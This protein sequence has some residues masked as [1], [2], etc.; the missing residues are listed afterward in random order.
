GGAL[1]FELQ[2]TEPGIGTDKV[3][4]QKA[5]FF[6]KDASFWEIRFTYSD[7]VGINVPAGDLELV[8]GGAL[9]FNTY[10]LA[11]QGDGNLVLRDPDHNVLWSSDTSANC[12]SGNCKATFQGDGNLVL[13]D[14]QGFYWATNTQD[15]GSSLHV[16]TQ[17][18]YLSILD[19]AG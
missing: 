13:Y 4:G 7:G 16:S 3:A 19:A 12:G 2:G 14:S 10:Q 11:F 5:R 18:P 9:W 8:P 6:N 1:Y 15:Q 17:S